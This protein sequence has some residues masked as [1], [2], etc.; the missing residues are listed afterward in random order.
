MVLKTG[1]FGKQRGNTWKVVKIWC[2][3]RMVKMSWKDRVKNE[4]YY[5][6]VRRTGISYIQQKEG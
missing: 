4:E 5:I 2:W 3:N 1:R 6:Q